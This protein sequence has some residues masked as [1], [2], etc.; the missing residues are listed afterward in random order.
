MNGMIG[1]SPHEEDAHHHHPLG[2]PDFEHHAPLVVCQ[3]SDLKI[4]ETH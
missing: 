1:D 3:S 4:S 2:F